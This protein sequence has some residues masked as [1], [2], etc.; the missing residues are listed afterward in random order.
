MR[1]L[2]MLLVSALLVGCVHPWSK[3]GTGAS[4][5]E[6]PEITTESGYVPGTPPWVP[7][8]DACMAQGATRSDC[9]ASLPPDVLE[10]FEASEREGA[11]RRGALMRTRNGE[12]AFGVR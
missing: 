9:I 12:E 6:Q 5:D 11:A 1:L 8:I 10:A 3:P 7:L 4:E 2:T